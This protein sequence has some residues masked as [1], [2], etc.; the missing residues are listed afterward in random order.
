MTDGDAEVMIHT[1]NGKDIRLY[2]YARDVKDGYFPPS[3]QWATGNNPV[4]LHLSSPSPNSAKHSL[5]A[6]GFSFCGE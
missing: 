5:A 6:R 1:S 2:A 3:W 4:F